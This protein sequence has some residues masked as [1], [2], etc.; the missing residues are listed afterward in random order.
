MATPGAPLRLVANNPNPP[1]DWGLFNTS[2]ETGTTASIIASGMSV[3][4]FG[5][6][7]NDSSHI[8]A[9]FMG[10]TEKPSQAGAKA[11]AE[12]PITRTEIAAQI[13]A[14][15]AETKTQIVQLQG[16]VET[17][18]SNLDHKIDTLGTKLDLMIGG[19]N[20]SFDAA[21]KDNK[22]TRRAM[23]EVGIGAVLAVLVLVVTLWIAGINIQG[24]LLSAFQAGLGALST[25]APPAS[26]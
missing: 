8:Y 20:E 3:N 11:M 22:E 14:A 13:R 4:P 9:P 19:M 24:N 1:T 5:P 18:F 17:R 26:K 25:K 23:W 10:Q 15:S 12:E 21:S 2:V 6:E 16:T 7:S